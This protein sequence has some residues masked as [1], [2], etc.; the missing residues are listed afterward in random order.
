[1]MVDMRMARAASFEFAN[2]GDDMVVAQAQPAFARSISVKVPVIE[3][4]IKKIEEP[5]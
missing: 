3:I 2:D 5:V 4:D 1:M